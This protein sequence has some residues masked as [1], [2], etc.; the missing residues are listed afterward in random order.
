M[1]AIYKKELQSYFLNMTGFVFI[2]F[3]LV[4]TGIFVTA[5]NLLYAFAS[6][7]YAVGSLQLVLMASVPLFSMRIIAEEKKSRTDQLLYS[8]PVPMYKVVLAKYLA[9]LTVFLIPTAVVSLYPLILSMFGSV[10]LYPSYAAILGFFLLGAS[11]IA[12]CMF[13]SSLSESQIIAAVIG[14]GAVLLLYMLPTLSS[15]L[16]ST[17]SASLIALLLCEILVAFLLYAVS[18]SLVLSIGGGALLVLPTIVVYIVKSSLFAG[19]I[20]R[21]LSALAVFS[22]FEKLIDGI[23]DVTAIVYYLSLIVFFVFLT[24]QSMEKKRYA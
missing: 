11:L 17:A 12:L 7:T 10:P 15:M 13:F 22:R 8:L 4:W 6:L 19:L 24:V 21:L 14:F 5:Y 20:Q 3:L 18:K 16:P 9:M 23:F 1:L 2:S